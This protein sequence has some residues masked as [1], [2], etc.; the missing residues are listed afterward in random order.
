MW[1][2]GGSDQTIESSIRLNTYVRIYGLIRKQCNGQYTQVLRIF[3]LEDLNELTCHFLE[4]MHY[5]LASKECAGDNAITLQTYNAS[6]FDISLI[7][8]ISELLM[9]IDEDF[10]TK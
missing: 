4:V 3:P 5:T 2:Q 8:L 10:Q 1:L 6:V 9:D 7:D